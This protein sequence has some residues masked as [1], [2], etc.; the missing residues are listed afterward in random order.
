MEPKLDPSQLSGLRP[1]WPVDLNNLHVSVPGSPFPPDG[2][3]TGSVV[4]SLFEL[5][6]NLGQQ[7]IVPQERPQGKP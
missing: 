1:G 6:A 2:R 7:Y 3:P 5:A 4:G